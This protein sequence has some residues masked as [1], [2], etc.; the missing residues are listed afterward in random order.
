MVAPHPDL[1]RKFRNTDNIARAMKEEL[2]PSLTTKYPQDYVDVETRNKLDKIKPWI[3]FEY[4][5]ITKKLSPLIVDKILVL[6]IDFSDK[7][8]SLSTNIIYNRFFGD[9]NSKSFKNYYKEVSYGQYVPEGE[10]H[11]WYRAPH[12]FTYYTG[13]NYGWGTYPNNVRRLVED[14]IDIASGD[15]NIDWASFDSSNN[16]VLSSII[17]VHSGAEA[18]A[19]GNINDFWAHVWGTVVPKTVG[20]KTVQV[21][22][23]SAEYITNVGGS[24]VSGVDC[25]EFGHLLGLPDLYD[26]SGNSNGV[27]SFSLMSSG[28]WADGG[29]TPVHLDAWSKYKLGFSNTLENPTGLVYLTEAETTKNNV[30]YTTNDVKE[31]FMLENRQKKL[32]DTFL[33]AHGM[34]IWRVNENKKLNND[35]ICFKVGLLQADGLRDLENKVNNGDLGD[36]FPGSTGKRSF[37]K[38]TNP[39][40]VLCDN[41]LKDIILS[42]I[43]DSSGIMSF[44]SSITILGTVKFIIYPPFASIYFGTEYKGNTNVDG[45][46]LIYNISEGTI[47][48]TIKKAGYY[49]K[50]GSVQVIEGTVIVSAILTVMPYTGSIQISSVPNGARIYIDEIDTGILTPNVVSGLSVGSHSYR[51]KLTGYNDKTNSFNIIAGQ[52]VNIDAG[53]LEVIFMRAGVNPIAAFLLVGIVVG[54]IYQK[55]KSK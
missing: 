8:S 14:V 12:E 23:L 5:N 17:I 27:G 22:A 26:Y 54:T 39:G 7:H 16:G 34:L 10:V 20:G 48:Y 52:T 13:G 41:T 40:S 24:Q 37:G 4:L 15:S 25:H 44:N 45:E 42:E 50:T 2:V 35:E 38:N 6:C 28:S 43:S 55:S 32:F 18:A 1:F 11:G 46:L 49:D 51:L 3:E 9:S 19:T 36:S 29:L 21:Y 47:S 33:P 53:Q 30:K 31:F